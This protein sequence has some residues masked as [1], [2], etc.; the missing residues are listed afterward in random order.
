[1]AT[2]VFL[3]A[4]GTISSIITEKL[5]HPGQEQHNP[6]KHSPVSATVPINSV[7]GNQPVT[8]ATP[9]WP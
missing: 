8:M 7:P 3:T 4:S 9:A 6:G 5:Q 1:M 2:K